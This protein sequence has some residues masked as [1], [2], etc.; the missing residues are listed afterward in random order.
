MTQGSTVLYRTKL[1]NTKNDAPE[2]IYEFSG[3]G[4]NLFGLS[5]YGNNLFLL[6]PPMRMKRVTVINQQEIFWIF[7]LWKHTKLL[8]LHLHPI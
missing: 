2:A 7:I 3:I 1:G 6:H 4:T 5:A 8:M